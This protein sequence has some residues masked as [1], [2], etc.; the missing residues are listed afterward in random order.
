MWVKVFFKYFMQM[1]IEAGKEVLLRSPVM[2]VKAFFKYFMQMRKASG[3]CSTFFDGKA[4]LSFYNYHIN[5]TQ[6]YQLHLL[7]VSY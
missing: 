2:W 6:T 3:I 1:R 5:T 4:I 7:R